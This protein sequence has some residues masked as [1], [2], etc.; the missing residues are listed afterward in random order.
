MVA[1]HVKRPAHWV[2]DP[3]IEEEEEDVIPDVVPA[4]NMK[5]CPMQLW[6]DLRRLNPYRFTERT[7][8]LDPRFWTQSQFAMWNDHY[9]P[10]TLDS[11]VT[12]L[13]LNSEHF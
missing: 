9:D 3:E 7:F 13:R 1:P 6:I 4:S 12:S 11:Y 5:N 10:T 2:R 8:H